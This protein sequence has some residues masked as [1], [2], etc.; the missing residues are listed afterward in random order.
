MLMN[1]PIRSLP[2]RSWSG[3]PALAPTCGVE[4]A[5]EA[6]QVLHFPHL[7]FALLTGEQALLDPGVGDAK[8][9]NISLRGSDD[10]LRGAADPSGQSAQAAALKAMLLRF[11]GQGLALAERLF[12]HYAGHLTLGN[13]SFRP[14]AVQ[15]RERSWR[16]DDS[17]LHVDA[18][19]SNPSRG[20]R[21]LRV[22]SNLNPQGA[23]RVWRV[24]EPFEDFARRQVPHLSRPFPGSAWLLHRLKLTKRRRSEYDHLMLQLHDR[25][26]A[27]LDWQQTAPQQRVEFAPGSTW[28]V[29]SDQVL[30]AVDAG[31]YMLEMT[32]LLDTDDQLQ[33]QTSPLRVLERLTGRALR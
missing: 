25:A 33:P 3:S 7:P 24:G 9:K 16:Q 18:F 4:A 17:R 30:H 10:S 22:F 29:F 23:P 15:G 8:A 20:Q 21:L 11:R 14:Y 12:P 5:V 19:P 2:D 1:D 31:Q 13:A 28:V 26:K 27:D 6:G 32:L